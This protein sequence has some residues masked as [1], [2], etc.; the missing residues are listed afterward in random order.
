MKIKFDI[1]NGQRTGKEITGIE[2]EEITIAKITVRTLTKIK[3][4]WHCCPLLVRRKGPT[5][6]I[7][8]KENIPHEKRSHWINDHLS[9]QKAEWKEGEEERVSSSKC[10][11]WIKTKT[12]RVKER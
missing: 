1:R 8:S 12:Y 6:P 4:H 5:G 3:T 11:K 9:L 2:T 7:N 10:I